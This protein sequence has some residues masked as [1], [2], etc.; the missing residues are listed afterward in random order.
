M[1]II[2]VEY[3]S[4]QLVTMVSHRIGGNQTHSL[5]IDE[6]GSKN[7]RNSFFQWGDKRQ[8]K[9]L[10][11]TIFDLRSSIVLYINVFNCRVSGVGL[12]SDMCVNIQCE[13]HFAIYKGHACM[14]IHTV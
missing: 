2:A 1:P 8:S 7:A 3:S 4:C 9:T 10:F 13:E 14:H 12:L 5:K 6:Q 11:L